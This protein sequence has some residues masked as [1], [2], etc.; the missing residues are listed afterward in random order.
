MYGLWLH[1]TQPSAIGQGFSGPAN[2]PPP[3]L[4]SLFSFPNSNQDLGFARS[5][6][7]KQYSDDS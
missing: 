4:H 5:I 1:L 3:I 7:N 2:P 6:P